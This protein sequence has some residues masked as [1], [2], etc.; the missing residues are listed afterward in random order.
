MNLKNIAERA[1][2]NTGSG[3]QSTGSVEQLTS[4]TPLRGIAACWVMVTHFANS[5][6][7]IQ[8]GRY[9]GAVSKGHLA[10]DLFFILSG[11]V[12]T[13]VYKSGFTHGVTARQYRSFLKARVARLYPLHLAVLLL[14]VTT[15][16]AERAA[17]YLL[18]GSFDPIPLVGERS[19]IAIPANL[20]MLQGLSAQLFW[21]PPTW[22][23]S[24]EFL[25]Y[26]LF[27]LLCGGLCRLSPLSKAAI[28]GLLLGVL[29]WLACWTGGDFNQHSGIFAIVRGLPEFMAG[30][31]LYTVYEN[32][33]SESV[34]ATDTAI[35]VV[36]LVLGALSHFAAPDLS[37]VVLFPLL[38]LTGVCNQGRFTRL[39]NSRPFVWLGDISYSVYLIHW[40]VLFIVGESAEHIVAHL[41]LVTSLLLM[42]AM[43][44]VSFGLATL[45]Y[46]FIEVPGRR[47][48]RKHLDMRRGVRVSER[49][50]WFSISRAKLAW[51]NT[52]NSQLP[53]ERPRGSVEQLASLTPLRGMA[54]LW[55]MIFHFVWHFPNIHPERYTGAVYKGYLAVD[56]FFVLSGFVLTH[57]YKDGFSRGLTTS[58]YANFLKARVARL[59]PLHLA[60]LLVFVAAAMAERAVTYVLDGTFD[61]LPLIGERSVIGLFANLVMLH[62]LWAQKL[63]WNEP[64]WSISLEFVAY[65]LFPLLFVVLRRA[66]RFGRT[67]IGCLILAALLW[68]A[69]STGDYFNQWNGTYAILRALAEFFAGALLYSVYERCAAASVMA[70]DGPLFVATLVLGAL[71]HLSAPDLGIIA[72]FPLLILTAA[73]NKGRLA[74]LLNSGPFCWLGD[75]S[76][77]VYL[78]HW[79]VLTVVLELAQL[80]PGFALAD[81]ELR[82]SLLAVA[83]MIGVSLGLATLSYRHIEVP[84]RRWLRATLDVGWGGRVA[85]HDGVPSA[86]R[87]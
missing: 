54:A 76:Y 2:C 16:M 5:L 4:L 15:V 12:I 6:P 68:L 37:I 64:A 63:N 70:T 52:G 45:S 17:T 42:A 26:L 46:R 66:G 57:V 75:I 69:Y 21:N 18:Y 10:V 1:R 71:L 39:L 78:L 33:A 27:P 7:S 65:L 13:H 38:I 29:C 3:Q 40:F 28:G 62:G 47:W 60:M 79:F 81:L 56:M 73:R 72:L 19:L 82:T 55:V 25:A 11:F 41:P 59:Y 80:I 9:T 49:D 35:L 87:A 14:F 53:W 58:R 85:A 51:R 67:A 86:S 77:S 23:I 31:L 32:R 22:S 50:R 8:H 20:L 74:R 43:M 83:A 24:V 30:A 48:L 34:L 44:A 61:P 36:F 84:G